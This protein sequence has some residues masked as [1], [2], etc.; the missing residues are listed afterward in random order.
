[1]L[2]HGFEV[3][4]AHVGY[5]EGDYVWVGGEGFLNVGVEDGGFFFGGT[6]L[7]GGGVDYFRALGFGHFGDG[8]MLV[9]R[10]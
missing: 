8:D 6:L 2:A 5:A 3:R 9:E 7:E 1:M 10:L 4:V